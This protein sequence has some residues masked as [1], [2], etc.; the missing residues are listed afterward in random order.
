MAEK[1]IELKKRGYNFI[2]YE[3]NIKN[4]QL[5]LVR[6]DD[7][8]QELVQIMNRWNPVGDLFQSVYGWCQSFWIMIHFAKNPLYP[9]L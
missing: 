9:V 2:Y 8:F 3:E 6:F 7:Q 4:N 1:E 5:F